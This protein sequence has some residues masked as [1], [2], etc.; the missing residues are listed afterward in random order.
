M[1]YIIKLL[2]SLK[3]L[4]L[5]LVPYLIT[6]TST[7]IYVK[8]TNNTIKNFINNYLIY[9]TII[10]Y[11][12]MII[13]LIKKYKIKYKKLSL[14]LYYSYL[15]LGISISCILNM[16]IFLFSKSETN[17]NINVFL[18]FISSS[19]IGPIFEEIIF[20]YLFYNKL[21]EFNSVKI[22]IVITTL[23]FSIIHINIIKICYAFILGLIVNIKYEKTNNILSPILIH[24][25]ANT[26]S[27]FLD[28]YSSNILLLA[29]L[30]LITAIK[31]DNTILDK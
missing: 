17:I 3:I 8:I 4:L 15:S 12:I 28:N 16:V 19:I 9:I 10:T 1:K 27:L 23:F 26:I 31:V 25:G 6:I 29:I 22:S 5:L 18:L 7:Y 2:K 21:K 20:R 11:I 24:I 13:Y 30:L 14:S